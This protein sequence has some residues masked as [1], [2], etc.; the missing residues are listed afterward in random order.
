MKKLTKLIFVNFAL[1]VILMSCAS[2]KKASCDAY[3]KT[4]TNKETKKEV[5]K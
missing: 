5:T 3:S 4:T 2:K 1:I